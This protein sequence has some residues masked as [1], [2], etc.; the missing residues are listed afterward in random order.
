MSYPEED[1][2]N[3]AYVA[4]KVKKCSIRGADDD[5]ETILYALSMASREICYLDYGDSEATA[6]EE[7]VCAIAKQFPVL[8]YLKLTS[9]GAAKTLSASTMHYLGSCCP[10]LSTLDFSGLIV[11]FDD[12]ALEAL[13][14]VYPSLRHVRLGFTADIAD[15]MYTVLT[16]SSSI[17]EVVFVMLE[18]SLQA[19]EEARQTCNM[20]QDMFRNVLFRIDNN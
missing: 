6:S 17:R 8:Q 18:D 12:D 5:I 10:L 3:S 14:Y 11:Y 7:V 20:M 4:P 15:R 1:Y 9:E 2:V 16:M 13:G 19:R